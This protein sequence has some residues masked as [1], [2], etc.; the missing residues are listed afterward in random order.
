MSCKEATEQK[1]NKEDE[2]TKRRWKQGR[3]PTYHVLHGGLLAACQ[4]VV[5][6]AY[7]DDA[8]VV[9]LRDTVEGQV[10]S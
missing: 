6:K 10:F 9:S 3:A 7:H 8:A 1:E 5:V 4:E 2:E